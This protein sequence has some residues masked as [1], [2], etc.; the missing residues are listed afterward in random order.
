MEKLFMVLNVLTKVTSAIAGVGRQRSN[1]QTVAATIDAVRAK[2]RN[3]EALATDR[4]YYDVQNGLLE[5]D[6]L[7]D[8]MEAT[9]V[10][11]RKQGG[12]EV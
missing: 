3:L 9:V 7:I 2:L 12:L 8:I 11:K 10:R 6:R 1:R 5:L 4:G